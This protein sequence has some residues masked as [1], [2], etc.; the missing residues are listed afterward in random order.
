MMKKSD[1]D[2][3]LAA[4]LTRDGTN[5]KR[6]KQREK[7]PVKVRETWIMPEAPQSASSQGGNSFDFY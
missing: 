5:S 7:T 4:T 3:E 1:K 2:M 6:G